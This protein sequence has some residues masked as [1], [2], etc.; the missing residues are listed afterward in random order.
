VPTLDRATSGIAGAPDIVPTLFAKSAGASAFV[1]DVTL[2]TTPSVA[3]AQGQPAPA[4][5]PA[6]R[7]TPNPNVP[8][9]T[10]YALHAL[11]ST[12]LILV[13]NTAFGPLQQKRLLAYH[14]PPGGAD[15]AEVRKRLIGALTVALRLCLDVA[16]RPLPVP[17][18]PWEQQLDRRWPNPRYASEPVCLNIGD[19][20]RE[21]GVVRLYDF[22]RESEGI[23]S[24]DV[25]QPIVF[26]V[27]DGA[28]ATLPAEPLAL[29]EW[30]SRSAV[31]AHKLTGRTAWI[32]SSAGPMTRAGNDW[33]CWR[34]RTRISASRAG[35][36]PTTIR[37]CASAS[38]RAAGGRR[39]ATSG[40]R[41]NSRSAPSPA[42]R[43]GCTPEMRTRRV[44]R[45]S[46]VSGSA[47]TRIG[48][49]ASRRSDSRRR[50]SVRTRRRYS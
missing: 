33:R 39:R 40:T 37:S 20:G 5:E 21:D 22:P 16:R 9:E 25:L 44:T 24:P 49:T 31:T 10:G 34:G 26:Q 14:L 19:Q 1:A 45:S 42:N 18:L 30:C 46:S 13:V 6:P 32:W 29:A 23:G 50:P 7:P 41:S 48:A 47:R 43:S 27:R 4:D 12:G 38:T 17:D 36:S 35:C 11:G 28:W 8:I 2:I 3:P 15:K